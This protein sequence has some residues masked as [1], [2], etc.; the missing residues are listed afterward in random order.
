MP[1]CAWMSGC[2]RG[3]GACR[4]VLGEGASRLPRIEGD[5][6]GERAL[7]VER[8]PRARD[9]RGERAPAEGS[10]GAMVKWWTLTLCS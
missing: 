2:G 1:G 8:L 7:A 6:R 3:E 9:C 5:C 4:D 10:G